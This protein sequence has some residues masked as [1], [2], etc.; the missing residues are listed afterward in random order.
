MLRFFFLTLLIVNGLLLAL[1]LGYLG[2]W[3]MEIHEPKRIKAEKNAAKLTLYTASAAQE[4]ID[5]EAKKLEPVVACLDV[6]NLNLADGKV[7]EEKLKSLALGA[8]Q[9]RSETAEVATNMVYLPPFA[10]KDAADKKAATLQKLGISDFYIVQDQT[11]LRW[12]ISLGVFKTPEAAKTYLATLNKKGL[13]EARIA[14]RS[15]A[16]AKVSFRL[17]ELTADE[18]KSFDLVK[19]PFPNVEVHECRAKATAG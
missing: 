19:E 3:S 5:A 12:S 18:K 15:V 9:T 7:F 11:P 16:V 13:K 4:I 14:P 6:G 1:N 10:S 17:L 8:R 2:D